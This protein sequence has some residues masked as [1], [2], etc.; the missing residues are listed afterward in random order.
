VNLDE[1]RALLHREP[2]DGFRIVLTSGHAYDVTDPDAVALMKKQ[3]FVA[4]PDGRW[5]FIPYLHIGA[6]ETLSPA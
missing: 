6:I 2:F 1:L 4:L 5:L 3:L